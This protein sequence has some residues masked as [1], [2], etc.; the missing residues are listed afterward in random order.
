MVKKIKD[1]VYGYVT[2]PIQYI[3]DII[4]NALFQRLRR[5]IQ[6]S[7]SPLYSSALHNRFVHS[8]GVLHLGK[9]V[10]ERLK[11]VIQEKKILDEEAAEKYANAYE[12]ACLLHDIGHAPFSHT[13]EIY[14]KNDK[15]QVVDLHNRLCQLV[16]SKEFKEDL[17]SESDSAAPHEIMSAIVGIKEFG[18]II[19]DK[20]NIELFAR[21][22]VGYEYKNSTKENEIKNCFIGM[23]NS[24]VIDVDR[25]DY[26][27]RDA[28]TSGFATMSIDYERLLNAL[29]VVQKDGH[30]K[31]AYQKD[32]V[33][34]IE[35]VV[36]AHDAERK[37]IQNH[38]IVLYEAYIIKHILEHLNEELNIE[39][40]RLFSEE[41]LSKEGHCLKDGIKVSLLCDDDIVYLSKNIFND[42]LSDEFFERGK[43]RHPVWKSEEEYNAYIGALSTGGELKVDFMECMKSFN[44]SNIP[45]HP[46]PMKINESLIKMF[47]QELQDAKEKQQESKCNSKQ[48]QAIKRKLEVCN[49]LKDYVSRKNLP[50]DFIIVQ[51][52]MFN[53]NFS[54]KHLGEMLIAFEKNDKVKVKM[55]KEV[56]NILKAD[57]GDKDFYYLFYRRK[58]SSEGNSGMIDDI[59]NFCRGLYAAAT[60][61]DYDDDEV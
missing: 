16:P 50:F 44:E 52:S 42:E 60:K 51:T 47:E 17:P 8:I 2:I 29:T 33:S 3:K 36:Y 6:T 30:Y 25:L 35:N 41:S 5:I 61:Y 11:L 32:A 39:G 58:E 48:V 27:I 45:D 24:K 49:Y 10:A 23:L 26:L 34:V 9:I 31:I 15:F 40:H 57:Y 21:C 12:L 53:S 19:G 1:P 59:G 22:I 14:Y 56:C 38:P 28:Y 55:F 54:K 7:Y 13:G 18:R 43:R 37:W 46:I 4:D 20:E